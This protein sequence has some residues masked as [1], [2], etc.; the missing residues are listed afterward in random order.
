MLKAAVS[1]TF[2]MLT[3]SLTKMHFPPIMVKNVERYHNQIRRNSIKYG[4]I[5]RFTRN[6]SNEFKYCPNIL[7][8]NSNT[9]EKCEIDNRGS[10]LEWSQHTGLKYFD[11]NVPE[12]KRVG[13]KTDEST[14]KILEN[15]IYM[16]QYWNIEFWRS[17]HGS[18]SWIS[19]TIARV[20]FSTDEK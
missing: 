3:L 9:L 8:T 19:F 7:H 6:F 2:K 16:I 4:E 14:F 17:A 13:Q 11:W 12:R 15:K 5:K 1:R 18:D 10:V 20:R